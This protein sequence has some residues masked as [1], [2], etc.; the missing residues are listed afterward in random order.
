M[1]NNK[2]SSIKDMVAIARVN[3]DI[4]S[5]LDELNTNY[6]LSVVWNNREKSK[7]KLLILSSSAEGNCCNKFG[8]RTNN[9]EELS[10]CFTLKRF[11]LKNRGNESVVSCR[12]NG[13]LITARRVKKRTL[14]IQFDNYRGDTT[15]DVPARITEFAKLN[16][17]RLPSIW[18][19]F[20][21]SD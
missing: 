9:L 7:D 21:K 6:L 1:R 3:Q 12:G 2:I 17:K 5:Q 14:A 8:F 19:R 4:F 11:R 20:F 18:E 16:L 15:E 10:T 13:L